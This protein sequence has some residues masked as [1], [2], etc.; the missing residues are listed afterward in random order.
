MLMLSTGLQRA[1]MVENY[2]DLLDE[3]SNFREYADAKQESL[4]AANKL[5]ET[6]T[7][8]SPFVIFGEKPEDFYNRTIH[9]GNIGTLGIT[10]ISS[11]VDIALTLPKIYDTLGDPNNG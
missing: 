4:D 11:Y 8:L 1:V 3:S 5:L 6:S 10:A 9:F 2:K 7:V